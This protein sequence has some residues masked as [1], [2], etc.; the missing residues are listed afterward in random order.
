MTLEL[1]HPAD[2]QSDGAMVSWMSPDRGLWVASRGGEYLGMIERRDNRYFPTDA[3]GR[4]VGSFED[5]TSAQIAVDRDNL[6]FDFD[7][8]ERIITRITIGL[9]AFSAL[10]ITYAL[11]FM[12]R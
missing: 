8:R 3:K 12:Q 2:A 1:S 4:S 10:G 9:A 7:R 5:F 11:A 6:S